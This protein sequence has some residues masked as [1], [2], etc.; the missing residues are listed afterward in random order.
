MGYF[1]ISSEIRIHNFYPLLLKSVRIL[2]EI[3]NILTKLKTK[4]FYVEVTAESLEI[5]LFNCRNV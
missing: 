3:H 1:F 5:S 2:N 4:T